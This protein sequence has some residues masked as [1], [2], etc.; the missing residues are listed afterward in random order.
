MTQA[1][2]NKK[3]VTLVELLAVIVI[4]GIIAAI[5]VPAI[6][7][8]IKSTKERAV[9]GTYTSITEAARLYYTAEDDSTFT[10]NDLV[11]GGYIT[12]ATDYV[13]SSQVLGEALTNVAHTSVAITVTG[14]SVS[15]VV[16]VATGHAFV[17]FDGIQM[18]TTGTT[19]TFTL[20]GKAQ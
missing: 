11:Q 10:L 13:Q 4:M 9:E 8:L 17:Y 19:P 16:T 18:A 5:A 6:G 7:G 1:L 20:T 2:K 15:I 14:T 3:G 12:L